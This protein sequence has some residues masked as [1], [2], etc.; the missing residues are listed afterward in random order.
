MSDLEY[1]S[2][3]FE[4]LYPVL[5]KLVTESA[6]ME[7]SLRYVVSWLSGNDDAGWIIFEGQSIDWLVSNGLAMVSELKPPPSLPSANMKRIQKVFNDAQQAYRLRNTMVH[8]EWL[9]DC[10][11]KEDCVKRPSTSP[12]DNRIFHVCRSRYR[13]GI[14]EHQVAI[15]DVELL[16]Q[17]MSDI[18]DELWH[19]TTFNRRTW[20]DL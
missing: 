4:A 1:K 14:E 11:M 18:K 15:I 2:N 13:K 8:G 5:G 6:S 17:R 10:L 12:P 16:S 20:L 19:L 3:E 7:I 9:L